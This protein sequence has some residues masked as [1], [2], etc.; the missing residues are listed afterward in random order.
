MTLKTRSHHPL[1]GALAAALLVMGATAVSA[2][3]SEG[4][5][6]P[7]VP[8]ADTQCSSGAFCLW[9]SGN[10]GGVFEQRTTSGS[11]SLTT[12]RSAW[13]RTGKAV[14]VHASSSGGG[15]SVCLTPGQKVPS[16]AMTTGYVSVLTTITCA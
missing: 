10:Y 5:G 4:D 9:S 7:V 6:L 8:M 16:T 2:V 1:V 12:A 11:V 3:A 15:T 14:R 13:N